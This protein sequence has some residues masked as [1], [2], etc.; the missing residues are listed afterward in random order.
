MGGRFIS[1]DYLKLNN[2]APAEKCRDA[3]PAAVLP[4]MTQANLD[5]M[6]VGAL[7]RHGRAMRMKRADVARVRHADGA[8]RRVLQMRKIAAARAAAVEERKTGESTPTMSAPPP[9]QNSGKARPEKPPQ[10][11]KTRGFLHIVRHGGGP[12]AFTS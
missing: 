10:K 9:A 4:A 6:A 5:T 3:A 8:E 2:A 12:G 11:A 7:G 1:A